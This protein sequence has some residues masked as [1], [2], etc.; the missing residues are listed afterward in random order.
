[1]SPLQEGGWIG[2]L[3]TAVGPSETQSPRSSPGALNLGPPSLR[4]PGFK[5]GMKVSVP[6]Q[7]QGLLHAQYSS[8]RCLRSKAA[9]FRFLFESVSLK[10]KMLEPQE[11]PLSSL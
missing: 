3:E 7:Q 10:G 1:M 2:D 9:R 4:F 8:S 11:P 6:A 5:T